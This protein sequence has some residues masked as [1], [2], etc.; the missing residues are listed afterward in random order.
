MH[1]SCITIGE[2]VPLS[3]RQLWFN[4]L[5][6]WAWRKEK[7]VAAR[8]DSLASR[9]KSNRI[10]K[11]LPPADCCPSTRRWFNVFISALSIPP[12][13]LSALCTL[14]GNWLC[15]LERPASE[16]LTST[17][18]VLFPPLMFLSTCLLSSDVP[19][20]VMLVMQVKVD[21]SFFPFPLDPVTGHWPTVCAVQ[22]KSSPASVS[23]LQ[24]PYTF[25]WPFYSLP[26]SSSA[27]NDNVI[28]WV[29]QLAFIWPA[30]TFI[31]FCCSSG[32][33]KEKKLN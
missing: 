9:Q 20:L 6:V 15:R 1:L 4:L 19:W 10:I 27:V 31:L 13:E 3:P 25:C 30:Y 28:L 5:V 23:C 16:D 21:C 14:P 33:N 2:D 8:A 32:D 26:S 17:C 29:G 12:H 24:W 18:E 22:V 11:L 7:V